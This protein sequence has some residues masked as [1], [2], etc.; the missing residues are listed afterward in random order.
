MI[1]DAVRHCPSRRQALAETGGQRMEFKDK[2]KYL[3]QKQ[4]MTLEQVGDAVGVGK[5]TVRK[6][7]TGDIAN[8]RRDKIDRLA[9][10]LHTN[11][12]YLMGWTEESLLPS[13]PISGTEAGE[14]PLSR[15]AQQLA[16]DY[17]AL[18]VWGQRTLRAVAD[19]EKARLRADI[20]P[21]VPMQRE[22]IIPLFGTA[23]AAGPGEPDTGEPWED[24]A[25]PAD[26]R[27][28]FA[29][30]IT[31][32]SMEPEL[33]S[34]QVA[35][36]TKRRPVNGE[37]AVLMVNGSLLCKQFITDRENIYLR[38]LNRARRDCD[39]DIWATGNDTVRCYGTVLHPPVPLVEE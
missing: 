36:C 27:A 13:A 3:R 2:L 17:D 28:E 19:A 20:A 31:G 10:A 34:G 15:Q 18:D 14:K 33:H 12:A 9:A 39:Y 30:R 22:K 16:E 29:V 1:K 26:S 7:E 23:A 11:P 6:W 35:M 37:L 24:Y 32:D 8:V 25:V 5:S 38:S 4:G 21:E